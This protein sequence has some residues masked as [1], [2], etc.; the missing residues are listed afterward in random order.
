MENQD[1]I[2][3]ISL[4][5]FSAMQKGKG[6]Q[7]RLIF[8]FLADKIGC[9]ISDIHTLFEG[10]PI[11]HV[12]LGLKNVAFQLNISRHGIPRILFKYKSDK[13]F[14]SKL[15]AQD[16]R[17]H[18]FI[19]MVEILDSQFKKINRNYIITG[20]NRLVLKKKNHK[21]LVI[22]IG[23]AMRINGYY[24]IKDYTIVQEYRNRTTRIVKITKR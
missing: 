11:E 18:L 20:I 8:P 21:Y 22:H 16:A 19:E 12:Y 3:K 5:G 17:E 23:N 14:A 7:K 2:D 1:L 24:K 13:I 9:S 10:K 4:A 15:K 6:E